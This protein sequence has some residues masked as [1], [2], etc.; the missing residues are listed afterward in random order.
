MADRGRV[1]TTARGG[2]GMADR[3]RVGASAHGWG[4]MANCAARG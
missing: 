2:G 4:G 1:G 3:S